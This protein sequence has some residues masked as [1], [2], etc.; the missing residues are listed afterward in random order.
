MVA[1]FVILYFVFLELPSV[2]REKDAPSFRFLFRTRAF[3]AETLGKL[4][5]AAEDYRLLLFIQDVG[6]NR[7]SNE[8]NFILTFLEF[9]YSKQSPADAN[10]SARS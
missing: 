9:R 3:A 8:H 4:D 5:K 7:S 2:S 1:I 10:K 6:L